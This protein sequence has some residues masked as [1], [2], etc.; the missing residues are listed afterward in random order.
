MRLRETIFA[1]M[2][3]ALLGYL[4]MS[5]RYFIIGSVEQTG[6]DYINLGFD[7]HDYVFQGFSANLKVSSF[8]VL[9]LA[10]LLVLTFRHVIKTKKNTR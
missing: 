8:L 7:F 1:L 2:I 5:G 9:I 10:P 3:P 4:Y 6:Y